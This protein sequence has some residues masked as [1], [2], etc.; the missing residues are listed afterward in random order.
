MGW[1]IGKVRDVVCG[2]AGPEWLH[3]LRVP[4]IHGAIGGGRRKRHIQLAQHRELLPMP[5]V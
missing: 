5:F 4:Y 2:R 3:V 1:G